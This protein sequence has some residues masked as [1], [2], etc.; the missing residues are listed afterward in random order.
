MGIGEKVDLKQVI[1]ICVVVDDLQR[2]MVRYWETFGIGPWHIYTFEPPA[3]T[4]T[5]IREESKAYTMKLALCQV[6]NL[7][8]ELIQPLTGPSIYREFLQQKGEGVHHLACM[9]DDYDEAVAALKEQ[10]IGSLMGGCWKGATYTYMDT[11]KHLGTVIELFQMPPGFEMPPP[12]ST[13][14]PSA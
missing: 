5:T 1:Q 3:L 6:G 14:P 12:E 9:V 10:G 7:Q 4:Q 11:E 2:A 13:Y 8:W